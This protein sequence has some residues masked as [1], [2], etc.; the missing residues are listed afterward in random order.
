MTK[1]SAIIVIC[2]FV[3][4]GIFSFT[5]SLDLFWDKN[6][7]DRQI[8]D[9]LKPRIVQ[10]EDNNAQ[11]GQDLKKVKKTL[12][13][14]QKTLLTVEQENSVISEELVAERQDLKKN[15]ELL[16]DRDE[17][18]AKQI[19]KN[20][21]VD[22]ENKLLKEKFNAMYVEFLEMKKTISSVEGLRKALRE[23]RSSSKKNCKT[24]MLVKT[25]KGKARVVDKKSDIN[26]QSRPDTEGRGNNGYLIRDGKSTYVPKVR[27]KV[28]TVDEP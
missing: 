7:L 19:G 18:L 20:N 4:V 23:L 5:K 24:V 1:Q 28:L 15:K 17:E 25:D 9:T 3:G 11:M 8:E 27:I 21:E 16:K 12:D 6:A 10:L 14:T 2:I 26:Q 13:E 22:S